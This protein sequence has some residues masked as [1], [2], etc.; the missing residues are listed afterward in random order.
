M[1]RAFAILIAIVLTFQIH[2]VSRTPQQ[3]KNGVVASVHEIASKVGV[4]TMERGGNAVDAA[5]AVALTLAVVWPEAGNLG[6][7]GFLLIRKADGTEE[8]IDYRERAPLAATREMYLDHEGNV[9]ANL[10]TSGYKAVA[11][12][13][14]IAGLELAHKRH[15]RLEWKE[16]IEP[17]RKIAEEGYVVSPIIVQR[18]LNH[19]ETLSLFPESNRIFLRGGEFYK[20]GERFIQPDLAATLARLQRL[21]PREFYEGRTAQLI[22]DAMRKNGGL[23]TAADLKT[24]EPTIRKPIRGTYRGYEIVT[25]PPPSSGGII[26]IEMLNM[27]E[28]FD[29]KS[30]GF[31]SAAHVHLMIEV[32]KRAFADRAVHLGDT[33]FVTVPVDTLISREHA[34]KVATSIQQQKTTPSGEIQP[35]SIAIQE[36]SNT[37]HFSV[38]DPEGTV[39]SSTYTINDSFGSGVTVEGAGFLLNN[40]MDDFTSKPGAPNFYGLLQSENNAIQP[41]KRPL[42]SMTPVIVLK[43]GKPYF[44]A[45][46]AGG[47]VIISAVL[48]MIVNVIDFGMDLQQA[49]DAPR[50]HHQWMPDEIFDE[51]FCINPDTRKI[52]E[53]YGHKFSTKQFFRD[54]KFLGDIHSVFIDPETGF[55]LGISDPRRGGTPAGF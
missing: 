34:N 11:V 31:Q 4:E 44:T 21:G 36:G 37:T 24:Y 42:S 33:D 13:G 52:L 55:R 54:T 10:S 48:Q 50:F 28:R 6:G 35:E 9:I 5:V 25:M 15:G 29:V 22:S 2:A 51:P 3:F 16:L 23:I 39:V 30:Y 12:P 45:G 47:P 49:I 14:T 46:S 20:P 7:G 17:A 38:V 40:E 32:M 8:A 19:K 18:T 26:L 1:K 27:L 53:G 43:G 41:R